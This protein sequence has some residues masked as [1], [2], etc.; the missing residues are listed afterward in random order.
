ML[1]KDLVLKIIR[2]KLCLEDLKQDFA[3]RFKKWEKK[4]KTNKR[5]YLSTLAICALYS[6]PTLPFTTAPGF[7]R[8]ATIFNAVLKFTNLRSS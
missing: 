8:Y 6:L 2:N 4:L 7:T 5:K 3:R 1:K